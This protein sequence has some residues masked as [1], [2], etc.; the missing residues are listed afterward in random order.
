MSIRSSFA[1]PLS[2]AV[3]FGALAACSSAPPDGP[4][5]ATNE[6]FTL[7]PSKNPGCP[8]GTDYQNDAK[9]C[10][11][12]GHVCGLLDSC[13]QGVCVLTHHCFSPSDCPLF[14]GKYQETCTADRCST[15]VIAACTEPKTPCDD[16]N[17]CGC[18]TALAGTDY[19]CRV[20]SYYQDEYICC[21]SDLG[22][23]DYNRQCTVTN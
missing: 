18:Q 15:S 19:T 4:S 22:F 17:V 8:F 7:P 5:T 3:V 12:C 1:V 16:N 20:N 11:S 9:N 23:D 6:A 13:K 10:G 14:R 2:F 21:P